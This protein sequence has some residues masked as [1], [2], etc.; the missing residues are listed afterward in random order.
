MVNTKRN[1]VFMKACLL[2]AAIWLLA[3]AIVVVY[4]HAVDRPLE[5]VVVAFLFSPG[6]GELGFGTLI[7]TAK[8]KAKTGCAEMK[9]AEQPIKPEATKSKTKKRC[10]APNT[11][12]V[13]QREPKQVKDVLEQMLPSLVTE[14]ERIFGGGI[15]PM[16]LSFV[17][18]KIYARLP[19][20]Y[21][22]HFTSEQ[23]GSMIDRA[24]AV[25]RE[26]WRRNPSLIA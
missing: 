26:L 3:V 23:L 17:L 19:D 14:A 21:K 15:G 24:L 9:L 10:N 13:A 7:K 25:T 12:T 1:G 2:I 5:P 22:M 6:I 16:K 8:E 18:E 20:A 4:F 11:E